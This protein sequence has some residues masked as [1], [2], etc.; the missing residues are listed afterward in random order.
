MTKTPIIAVPAPT[1]IAIA[2]LP[3]DTA[4]NLRV[5][6]V[7]NGQTIPGV[8][9]ADSVAGTLRRFD[10]EDGNLVREG[11]SFRVIEEQRAISIEWIVL[12]VNEG[13][14]A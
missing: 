6:D 13:G 8:I 1:A 10:V 4:R 11:D 12:P 14:A 3:A 2:S 9:E 7:E 5:V